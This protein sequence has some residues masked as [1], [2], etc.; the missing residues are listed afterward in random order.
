M[1]LSRKGR[2][3]A[4]LGT[5]ASIATIL[6][7][8]LTLGQNSSSSSN[9]SNSS[10]TTP[11]TTAATTQ[12]AYPASV[13]QNFLSSCEQSSNGN[14]SFCQCTLN[15]F[16]ANVSLTQFEADEDLAENGQTP[17]DLTKAESACGE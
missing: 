14:V 2:A 17:T 3:S 16:Q 11:S 6:T 1:G 7:L 10:S 13:D 8:F 5:C 12:A 15:W 4:I 9:T